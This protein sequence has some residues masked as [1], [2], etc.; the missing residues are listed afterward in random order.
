MAST[1]DAW[2]TGEVV[3]IRSKEASRVE[4]VLATEGVPAEILKRT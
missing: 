2:I 1:N 4:K 3:A